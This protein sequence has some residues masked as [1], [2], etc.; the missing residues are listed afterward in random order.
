MEHAAAATA[1]LLRCVAEPVQR[2]G[3]ALVHAGIPAVAHGLL[4]SD[5]DDGAATTSAT[6]V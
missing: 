1:I 5:R 6:D 2:T 3:D 4:D